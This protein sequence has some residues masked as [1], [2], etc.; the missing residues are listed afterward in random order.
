MAEYSNP[1]QLHG[2]S[3]DVVDVNDLAGPHHRHPAGEIDLVMPADA[4]ARF[5][6][7]AAGWVIYEA[8][9]A[10]HSSVS[11][12]RALILYLL[13]DGSIEFTR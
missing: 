5:D 4:E 10:H 13:P 9:S 8:G 12:G 2:F 1:A 7:H 3:V 11:G 6:G